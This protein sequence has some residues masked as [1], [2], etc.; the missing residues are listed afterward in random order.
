M[1]MHWDD[2]RT[3][4]IAFF[5]FIVPWGTLRGQIF[6]ENGIPRDTSFT[7]YSAWHSVLKLYS[8]AVPTELELRGGVRVVSD[9]VYA[10]V[11][12]RQLRMDVFLPDSGGRRPAV[13]LIHGGGW[14]SGNPGMEFPMAARLAARGYVAATVEHRLSPEARYPA[15][16]HDIKAAIRWM[17]A[18]AAEYQVDTNAIALYGASSGGHLAALVG[19]TAG[20]PYFD[21]SEGDPAV[22]T[23]VQAIIDVDGVLDLTHPAES[24]KDVG[25]A[26]PSVGKLWLGFSFKDNPELWKEASPVNHVTANAPPVLFVNSSLARFHAGRD[27][28]IKQLAAFNIDSEV[29]TI[30]D[31]PHQF[32]LFHPWA[33]QVV[34]VIV[35]FLDR[36]GRKNGNRRSTEHIVR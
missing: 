5:L 11:G 8:H 18:H 15:A 1:K 21:G 19:M 30:P 9:V 14:R 12:D 4:A 33:D 17:R 2:S 35:S 24:G 29:H 16:V 32:W 10:S 36:T 28:V 23:R 31:T 6:I 3:L 26:A 20:L 7:L 22:S 13:L 25:N 34:D 27:E